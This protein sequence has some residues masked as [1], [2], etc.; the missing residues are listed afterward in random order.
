[1]ESKKIIKGRVRKVSIVS[2]EDTYD[3]QTETSNFFA[4]GVL[5]HNSEIILR[6]Y[7]FC[8]SPDTPLITKDKIADISTFVDQSVHIWNGE[9][10]TP[11]T[12]RK[13]GENQKLVR[14]NLSDGSYLD[15]TP[16]HRWSVKDRFSKEWKEV[17]AKDLIGSSKYTLQVEPANLTAHDEGHRI[18]NAYTLGFAYGDGCVYKNRVIID[19]YG[20][21]DWKCPIQG[22]RHKKVLKNGYNVE[23]IRIDATKEVDIDLLKG[24]KYGD[25][26][27]R[28]MASWSRD[29]VLEFVAGLADADGSETGTGGIRI[30]ISDEQKARDL[31]LVLTKN[32]IRASVNLLHRAGKVTNY[33]ARKKALWYLQ[34]TDCTDIP[35]HRLNTVHGHK[36]SRKGNYQTIKSVIELDGLYDTYCFN[37]PKKH[38]GLFGNVLTYQCNLSEVVVRSTDTLDD[39]TRKVRLATILGT[40]QSTLSNFRYINKKWKNNTEEERLL[41]VSLTG[42][43]DH[44]VLN[45]SILKST[46]NQT[47]DHDSRSPTLNEFLEILRLTAVKTNKEFA[48][49]IGVEES[50]AITCVKPSGCQTLEGKIK[51]SEGVM[52]LDEIF[53][54]M[55]HDIEHCNQGDWLSPTKDLFVYDENNELQPITKLYVNGYAEVYEIEDYSGEIWK[56]TGNHEVKTKRGW[57]RVDQLSEQ[58]EIVTF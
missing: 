10:W 5:V 42:I 33:G 53:E 24:L 1:M 20:D 34:I 52:T 54:Y 36:P 17:Q 3:I 55:G 57:I 29:S 49:I 14:V 18:H 26:T 41:G 38:K 25:L 23:C 28:E 45:G 47:F 58:D 21:K 32:G 51:T 8:V 11:V 13:T 50:A 12:V 30:Y 43:M 46:S 44:K 27:F 7:Q 56:F 9:E 40:L 39:L 48:K 37:E 35:C 31:H 15:C 4:N 6:P 22:S 16:D 19:A 2:N